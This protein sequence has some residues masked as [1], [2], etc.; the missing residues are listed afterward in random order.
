MDGRDSRFRAVGYLATPW[1][2]PIVENP[3]STRLRSGPP[4]SVKPAEAV[5]ELET[6]GKT[7]HKMQSLETE[8]AE[9]KEFLKAR[10]A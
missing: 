5:G 8:V 1:R 9:C 4:A 3:I 7:V 10:K 2:W 6:M